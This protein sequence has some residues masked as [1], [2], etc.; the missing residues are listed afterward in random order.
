MVSGPDRQQPSTLEKFHSVGPKGGNIERMME[1]ILVVSTENGRR[2]D[3]SQ[4]LEKPQNSEN[5]L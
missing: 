5:Y 2:W 3:Q 1:I 4:K